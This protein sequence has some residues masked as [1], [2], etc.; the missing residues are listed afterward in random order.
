[1]SSEHVPQRLSDAERD[2]AAG[3]LR[4][5]FEA[6]RIDDTEFGDRLGVVLAAR[7]ST[8]FAPAFADLP[9]P[10]PRHGTPSAPPLP[11][12][13]V[14]SLP[15]FYAPGSHPVPPVP[16]YQPYQPYQA[17]A[18]SQPQSGLARHVPLARNL[19]WPVAIAMALLTGNWF[20]WI[21]LAIV[22]GIVLRQLG[23]NH[24]KPPPYLEQ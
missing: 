5:H 3:M 13:S 22:G 21:V 9:D 12:A 16:P 1:M 15:A 4:E 24:R 18:P 19:L 6:G 11:G 23:G 8:D 14:P 2:E 17:I 7:Y 10:H 20:L